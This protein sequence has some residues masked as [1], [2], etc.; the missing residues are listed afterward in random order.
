MDKLFG[1]VDAVEVGENEGDSGKVEAM[2]YSHI[3]HR[4]DEKEAAKE[5]VG[6]SGLN[7]SNII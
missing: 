3:E 1:E 2:I 7:P 5:T 4:E 6:V